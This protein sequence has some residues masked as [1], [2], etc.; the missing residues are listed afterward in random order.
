MTRVFPKCSPKALALGCLCCQKCPAN[1]MN[2]NAGKSRKVLGVGRLGCRTTIS[3]Q[4]KKAFFLR[5]H[6]EQSMCV[7]Q[8][9]QG[10]GWEE[11]FQ[12]LEQFTSALQICQLPL[13]DGQEHVCTWYLATIIQQKWKMLLIHCKQMGT[14]QSQAN[15]PKAGSFLD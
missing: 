10:S 5:S 2:E 9:R 4:L 6:R 8:P 12:L 3:I 13:Q 7:S 1:R 11:P 14:V 15:F